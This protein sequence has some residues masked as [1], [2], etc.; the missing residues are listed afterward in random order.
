ML[1][2]QQERTV[3]GGEDR[4]TSGNPGS[5]G[6]GYCHNVMPS[7]EGL[8]SVGFQDIVPA[9]SPIT[10]LFSDAR[11]IYGSDRTRLY[12]AFDSAGGIYVLK[13]GSTFWFK[14]SETAPLD[15]EDI[16]VGTVNGISYIYYKAVG[17]V[18]YNEATDALDSVTLTSIS[19][20]STL[21]VVAS[22]GYLIAY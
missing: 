8:D 11:V 20:A 19:T 7:L 13:S 17:C 5:P 18:K 14:L 9:Y 15:S 6:V 3:I 10:T 22:Y 2:E 4:S 21:G 12:L 16:T 1:S